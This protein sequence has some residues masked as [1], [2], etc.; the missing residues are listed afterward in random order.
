M[1]TQQLQ[2]WHKTA[3]DF[4]GMVATVPDCV[5]F[6]PNSTNILVQSLSCTGSH[7]ISV[8]SLGQYPGTF[9]EALDIFVTNITMR[10]ASD[11]ARIKVWPDTPSAISGDLQYVSLLPVTWLF[12]P[13][14]FF[15]FF[16]FSYLQNLES[17][18]AVL[19]YFFLSEKNY[20]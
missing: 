5:S 1:S 4:A 11:G 18:Y 16:F 15:F 7:G 8:G 17:H 9:D 2:W 19:A 14:E 6:K 10:N 12:L 13:P 20:T 3:N